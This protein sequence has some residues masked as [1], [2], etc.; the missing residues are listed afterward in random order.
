MVESEDLEESFTT[1]DAH[2]LSTKE[3]KMDHIEN[4]LSLLM[5]D[6]WIEV[7]NQ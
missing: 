3:F 2:N 4:F 1:T 6:G 5:N 7:K